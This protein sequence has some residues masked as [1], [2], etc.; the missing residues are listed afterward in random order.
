MVMFLF[1]PFFSVEQTM[2][3]FP[4][5]KFLCLNA[6]ADAGKSVPVQ[7][8]H[9]FGLHMRSNSAVLKQTLRVPY[10]VHL[11]HDIAIRTTWY[12]LGVCFTPQ[13]GLYFVCES[14]QHR[15]KLGHAVYSDDWAKKGLKF[16]YL[17]IYFDS[18]KYSVPEVRDMAGSLG[19][20]TSLAGKVIVEYCSEPCTELYMQEPNLI[21][22]FPAD[23]THDGEEHLAEDTVPWIDEQY[24]QFLEA[25][26][27]QPEQTFYHTV[28]SLE[29]GDVQYY[30]ASVSL[31]ELL[32]ATVHPND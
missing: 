17:D 26:E 32:C 12:G 22:E 6:A 3:M 27:R 9:K 31:Q 30:K 7:L 28:H 23:I 24:H 5:L 21:D 13:A 16:D 11:P 1:L 20:D 2:D 8:R 29:T 15:S 25:F 4:S 19:F 10:K 18:T 14:G